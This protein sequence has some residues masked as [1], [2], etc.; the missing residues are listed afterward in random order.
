MTV[1]KFGRRSIPQSPRSKNMA[2]SGLIGGS[3]K[4]RDVLA[5]INMVAPVD[6]SVLVR[7]ET[8]TRKEMMARALHSL[9]PRKS[10]AFVRPNCA[11]TPTG[12]LES[13]L[14]GH[15]RGEIFDAN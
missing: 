14:F 6:C 10:D 15:D 2:V 8:G 1:G 9:S 13:E 7:E 3:D 12:F 11:A 4:F 5:E